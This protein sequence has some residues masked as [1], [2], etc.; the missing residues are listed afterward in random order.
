MA[1]EDLR[2]LGAQNWRR[3]S[4]ETKAP[5]DCGGSLSIL[6]TGLMARYRLSRS[7]ERQSVALILPGDICDYSLVTGVQPHTRVAALTRSTFLQLPAGDAV[8]MF[9]R[10]PAILASVLAQLSIDQAVTEELLFSLGHRTALERSAHLLCELEFRLRRM[11]LSSEGRF[12]L[13]MTQAEIGHHLGL[14]AVHVNRTMQ[15]LRRRE[16][17]TTN[18]AVVGL[19]DLIKL[20]WLADFAP[21]YLTGTARREAAAPSGSGRH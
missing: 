5:F 19:P 16:L 8:P 10:F 2:A 7:G 9:E 15:E 18:G 6:A 14:T 13:S 20:Q 21:D 17:I 12:R 3:G 4:A 11:G 1:P